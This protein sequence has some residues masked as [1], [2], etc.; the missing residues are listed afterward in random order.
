MVH[1]QLGAWRIDCSDTKDPDLTASAICSWKQLQHDTTM[2]NAHLD[3]PGLAVITAYTLLINAQRSN[4]PRTGKCPF[5][6]LFFLLWC[7]KGGLDW[8]DKEQ[9]DQRRNRRLT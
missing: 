4:R 8:W 2:Q 3:F 9:E 7:L 6:S 1:G 5:P